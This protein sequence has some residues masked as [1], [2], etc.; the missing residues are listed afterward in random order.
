VQRINTNLTPLKNI[1]QPHYVKANTLHR[2][3]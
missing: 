2:H 3:H 1:K